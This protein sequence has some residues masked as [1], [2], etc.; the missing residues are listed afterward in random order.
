MSMKN[1]PQCSQGEPLCASFPRYIFKSEA[2]K[3]QSPYLQVILGLCYRKKGRKERGGGTEGGK[4]EKTEGR[5]GRRDMGET[6]QSQ[7]K[8]P[9]L[10]A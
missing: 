9:R 1:L 3:N 5:E 4:E 6:N 8:T 2:T 10:L 7:R